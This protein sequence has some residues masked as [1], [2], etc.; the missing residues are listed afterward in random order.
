METS[1]YYEY[2][3]RTRSI[4]QTR[5]TSCFTYFR[6]GSRYVAKSP[7]TPLLI[8]KYQRN[9]VFC[10]RI[11]ECTLP[12]ICTQTTGRKVCSRAAKIRNVTNAQIL[13]RDK[14]SA[15]SLQP[16]NW[17][18]LPQRLL[19]NGVEDEEFVAPL[20]FSTPPSKFTDSIRDLLTPETFFSGYG[21]ALKT[22]LGYHSVIN[23]YI[24]FCPLRHKSLRYEPFRHTSQAETVTRRPY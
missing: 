4:Y 2:I 8:F 7:I 1:R 13:R 6:P 9:Q 12:W 3:T 22:R 19:K 23:S 16:S 5:R 24:L 11:W 21:L 20:E 17:E 18:L 15:L 14:T 10:C